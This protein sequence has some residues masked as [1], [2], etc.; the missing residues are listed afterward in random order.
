[1]IYSGHW[2]EFPADRRIQALAH[3]LQS[4]CA[5]IQTVVAAE[6]FADRSEGFSEKGSVSRRRVDISARFRD[7][8]EKNAHCQRFTVDQDTV[9]IKN[10]QSGARLHYM[11]GPSPAAFPERNLTNKCSHRQPPQSRR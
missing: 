5:D 10:D 4:G 6:Q 11:R 2:L 1:M 8:R 3:V 9:A 7:R